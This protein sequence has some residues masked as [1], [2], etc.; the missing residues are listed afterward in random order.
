MSDTAVATP[1]APS[2]PSSG[3][4]TTAPTSFQGMDWSEP[5]SG[6]DPSDA[7]TGTDSTPAPATPAPDPSAPEG[8]PQQPQ[9]PIPYDR[10]KAILENQRAE[11]VT[12]ALTD[13]GLNAYSPEQLKA[14]APWIQ[15]ASSDPDGFLMD[16]LSSH[17]QAVDLLSKALQR[18]QTDP[19]HAA[20]LRTLVGKAMQNLRGQGQQPQAPPMVNV[21][22]EDGSVVAMPRDPGA[23]LQYHQQQWSK[24]MD[25]RFAPVT[26]TVEQMR[27]EHQ[28]AEQAAQVDHF[29]TT[30]HQDVLTWDGMSDTANQQKLAVALQQANINPND[31]REVA[32]A[33]NAAYRRVIVPTLR[34]SAE[35]AMLD[36]LKT[37]AAA[38]TGVNPGS[39][40]PSSPRT[41]TRFSDLGADAWK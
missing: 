37:K 41:V 20:T 19:R 15:R 14:I 35:S 38:A 10:H 4:T 23:W 36:N 1:G 12:K 39:A 25:E 27:A 31:P 18:L 11:A 17:P 26:Q 9:G 16:E 40:A 22:L 29:V 24:Q 13:Y 6:S 30:T 33:M 32:L 8:V 28:A 21:Q 34:A 7:P 2:A 3:G 5:S